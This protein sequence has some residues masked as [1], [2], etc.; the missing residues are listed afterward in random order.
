MINHHV[1]TLFN[2]A[3][4]FEAWISQ[5]MA[6]LKGITDGTIVVPNATAAG[7][8]TNDGNGKNIAETYTTKA[9]R[10]A[11]QAAVDSII[12][13]DTIVPKATNALAADKATNDGNGKNIAETYTTNEAHSVTRNEIASIMRGVTIVPKAYQDE[14]GNSIPEHYATKSELSNVDNTVDKVVDG[15]LPAGISTRANSVKI[16]NTYYQIVTS[17]NPEATGGGGVI[18]FV[19]EE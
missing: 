17:T 2:T 13:G 5:T 10:A 1:S 11:T 19:L 12:N 16:G 8:A 4:E 9:E 14:N 7:R 18:T 6:T 3:E 15:T